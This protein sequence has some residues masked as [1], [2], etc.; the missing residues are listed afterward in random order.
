MPVIKNSTYRRSPLL[1]NGHIETIYP[2]LFRKIK[3][4]RYER[5]R[6]I[7]SDGDFVDLDWLDNGSRSLVVLSHGLEGDS[8]RQYVAGMGRFFY[9]KKM[10]RAGL[11]LP[12][13]Q[14]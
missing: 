1:F 10:G 11:E 4:I 9:E 13:L 12:L 7:L 5:E 6:L 14:W 3:G 8:S 2:A